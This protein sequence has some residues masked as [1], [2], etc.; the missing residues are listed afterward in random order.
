MVTRA[1]LAAW[2]TLDYRELAFEIM[3]KF[4]DDLPAQDLKRMVDRTYTAAVFGDDAITPLKTLAP[5]LHLLRLSNGPTLAFKDIAMQLLGNL[6]EYV[7]GA[8]ARRAQ[9]ARRN[10]RRY[11]FERRIRDAGQEAG[12]AYSCSRRIER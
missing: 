6:F 7:L 9:R 2:R 5:G 8:A 11:R 1:E 12:C 10:V 3:R 4:A